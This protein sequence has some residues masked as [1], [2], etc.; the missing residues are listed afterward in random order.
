MDT[1]LVVLARL[2]PSWDLADLP[3]TP[4]LHRS[5]YSPYQGDPTDFKDPVELPR[6]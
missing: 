4:S 2:K 6:P 3:E 1:Q 5:S